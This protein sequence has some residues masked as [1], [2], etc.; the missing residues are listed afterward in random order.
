LAGLVEELR[1]QFDMAGED[2]DIHF[3]THL[4]ASAVVRGDRVQLERLLTNLVTNAI[5]YSHEGGT[6][7][8]TLLANDQVIELVV[9]DRGQGIPAADIPHIF[10]RFYRVRG[11]EMDPEK[12]LGLGLSFVAWI[13]KAHGGSIQV[14]SAVGQGSRF[15]V[16]LPTVS[17]SLESSHE[18]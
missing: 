16:S 10:D 13:V 14:E 7:T 12:G 6:V 18:L 15:I 8:V 11:R 9:E 17:E 1:E 3:E 5:K 2:H 4:P